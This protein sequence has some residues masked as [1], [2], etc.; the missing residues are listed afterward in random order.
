MG[1]SSFWQAIA[2]QPRFVGYAITTPSPDGQSKKVPIDVSTGRPADVSDPTTWAPF[3]EAAAWGVR[4]GNP[5]GVIPL[6]DG[7]IIDFDGAVQDGQ[8]APWVAEQI[9]AIGAETEVSVSG[10]GIHITV[11]LTDELRA[12]LPGKRQIRHNG[13]PIAGVDLITGSNGV[14][15][16]TPLRIATR[17]VA[18]QQAVA[19]RLVAELLSMAEDNHTGSRPG[20]KG[21]RS[22][23][24]RRQQLHQDGFV[25]LDQNIMQAARAKGADRAYHGVQFL[26]TLDVELRGFIDEDDAERT[27]TAAYQGLRKH[28][29]KAA[30]YLLTVIVAKGLAEREPFR[31]SGRWVIRFLSPERMARRLGTVPGATVRLPIAACLSPTPRQ[32]QYLAVI[33]KRSRRRCRQRPMSRQA[34]RK[35]TGACAKTQRRAERRPTV[36]TEENWVVG[37]PPP[38]RRGARLQDGREVYRISNTTEVPQSVDHER[39]EERMVQRDDRRVYF[40]TRP[41]SPPATGLPGYLYLGK[42]LLATGEVIHTWEKMW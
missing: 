15:L 25:P 24:E 16:G 8:L 17:P 36:K 19:T 4:T 9:A 33:A 12:L 1:A 7:L 31:D 40:D 28:P 2:D 27:L 20:G 6:A 3:A 14:I 26:R 32:E 42:S 39:L 21:R 10:T 18:E 30:R 23:P 22:G 41:D 5:V 37:T 29:E 35:V 11:P 38:G 13:L 34:K